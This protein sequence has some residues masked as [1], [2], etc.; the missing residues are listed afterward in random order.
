MKYPI[1]NFVTFIFNHS[2]CSHLQMMN[3]LELGTPYSRIE[4]V[5]EREFQKVYM[6]PTKD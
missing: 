5:D 3:R 1:H 4:L 2:L 6:K